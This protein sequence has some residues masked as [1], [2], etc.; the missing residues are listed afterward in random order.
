MLDL[1]SVVDF[2]KTRDYRLKSPVDNSDLPV[3]FKLRSI[4][5]KHLQAKRREIFKENPDIDQDEL[6]LLLCA[7]CVVDVEGD[8]QL[9][10]SDKAMNPKK[11]TDII[12]VFREN[13]W[14]VKYQLWYE[15]AAAKNFTAG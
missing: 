5:S 9:P 3:L 1:K 13:D 6:Q 2:E 4:D 11:V 15:I 10:D 12:K 14:I 8:V 7:H